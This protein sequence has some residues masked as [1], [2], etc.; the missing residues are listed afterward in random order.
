MRKAPLV[1]FALVLLAVVVAMLRPEVVPAPPPAEPDVEEFEPYAGEGLVEIPDRFV[2]SDAA[3]VDGG[4]VRV[5]RAGSGEHP[6]RERSPVEYGHEWLKRNQAENGSWSSKSDNRSRPAV[7]GLVLLSYFGAGETHKHGRYRR[8]IKDALRRLKQI[9]QPDG[10]FGPT[11][12]GDYAANHAIATLAMCE[13]YLQ[14]GSP[15][16]KQSAQMGV[17]RIVKREI[18]RIWEILALGSAGLAKLKVPENW[19]KDA[20]TW[21]DS[22]TNPDT[23]VASWAAG[24][25]LPDSVAGQTAATAFGRILSGE[26]PKKSEV[27]ARSMEFV[28]ANR[29]AKPADVRDP[30]LLLFGSLAAW[31][32]GGEVW[33]A[34]NKPVLSK[35]GAGQLREGDTKGTWDTWG[36]SDRLVGRPGLTA[37]MLICQ[38]VYYRY[39]RSLAGG[40]RTL[41]SKDE[42]DEE[43]D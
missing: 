22:V 39:D 38:Q 24:G 35:I 6:P 31:Q 30:G 14:T 15:L 37:M 20:L 10:L 5:L 36:D 41:P 34:W 19:K 29:P 16:F 21:L 17:D 11:G 4:T 33:K 12:D 9:Q 2:K 3:T 1:L 27:V 40:I 23:G 8:T 28:I 25:M 32:C 7:T 42:E 13:A 43:E 18:S 26:D